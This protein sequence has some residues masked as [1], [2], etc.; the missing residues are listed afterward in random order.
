MTRIRSTVQ[1]NERLSF[2]EWGLY[3]REQCA[4]A[5]ERTSERMQDVRHYIRFEMK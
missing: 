3:V 1:P 2:N 4:T 5:H